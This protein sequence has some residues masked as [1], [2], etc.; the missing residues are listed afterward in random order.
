[1]EVIE[2]RIST[3][4]DEYKANYAHMER[5]VAE[6]KAEM[7]KAREDRSEKALHRNAELGKLPVQK[8]LDLLLDRNTPWLEIAP[9]AAKGLYD[10]KVHGAGSRG[11]IGLVQGREVLSPCQ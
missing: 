3:A 4:S 10:G 7:K 2:T 6:L 5:L 11:G 1:M 8:R 9:L